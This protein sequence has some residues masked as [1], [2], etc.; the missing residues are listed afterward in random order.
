MQLV[1]TDENKDSGEV[2][3]LR[4]VSVK[5]DNKTTVYIKYR[6]DGGSETDPE[7]SVV[8]TANS[9]YGILYSIDLVNSKI[10]VKI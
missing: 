3:G 4:T 2:F 9:T 5:K 10:T 1:G 6:V 8:V 7:N